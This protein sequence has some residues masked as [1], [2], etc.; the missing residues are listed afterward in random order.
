MEQIQ[1]RLVSS[2]LVFY[3]PLVSAA[4]PALGNLNHL[5]TYVVTRC[6]SATCLTTAV[7]RAQHVGLICSRLMVH[8][9]QNQDLA[10]SAMLARAKA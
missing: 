6:T 10:A 1:T 4:T 7:A 3:A 8:H 9:A 2:L 5:V